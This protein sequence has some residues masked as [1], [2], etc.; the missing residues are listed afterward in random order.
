[1]ETSLW[2][3]KTAPN[4]K[5]WIERL[6]EEAE[7]RIFVFKGREL[8]QLLQA[9]AEMRWMPTQAWLAKYNAAF[10]CVPH[11]CTLHTC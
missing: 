3:L 7:Q 1:L 5:T 11:P 4:F 6:L 10:K 2:Y 9:L 8:V